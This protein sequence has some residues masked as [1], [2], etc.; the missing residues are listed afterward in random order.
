MRNIETPLFPEAGYDVAREGEVDPRELKQLWRA[1]VKEVF[2]LDRT[3]A[4]ILRR[5]V[6]PYWEQYLKAI[7]HH[8]VTDAAI[9]NLQFG[10]TQRLWQPIRSIRIAQVTMESYTS[11]DLT[12]ENILFRIKLC[13]HG[14]PQRCLIIHEG[15]GRFEVNLRNQECDGTPH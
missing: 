2:S 4:M 13:R 12:S 5:I 1:P 7:A 6:F 11:I 10:W 15:R 9:L 8:N 14:N 3:Q